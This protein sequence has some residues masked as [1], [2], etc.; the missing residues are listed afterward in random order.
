MMT[1]LPPAATTSSAVWRPIPLLPPTTTS[2]CPA[3]TDMACGRPGP[4]A[5]WCRPSSQFVLILNIPFGG[6]Y[7]WQSVLLAH[8]DDQHNLALRRRHELPHWRHLLSLRA[9]G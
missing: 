2:F 9:N 4:S 5:C 1:A 3:K 8:G 7:G 6:V